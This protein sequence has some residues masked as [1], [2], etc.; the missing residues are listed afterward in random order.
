MN[1][2]TGLLEAEK[3]DSTPMHYVT[4]RFP[5]LYSDLFFSRVDEISWSLSHI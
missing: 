5:G 3:G 1:L 2:S 4:F